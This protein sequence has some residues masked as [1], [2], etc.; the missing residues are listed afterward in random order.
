[1]AYR[2]EIDGLRAIAVGGVVA[3]HAGLAGLPGGFTGVDVFFVISGYLITGIIAGE[4]AAGRFSQLRFLERRI[5]RIVPAL[6][7][8]LAVTAVAAWTLLTPADFR[9]FAQSLTASAVFGSNLLFARGSDYFDSE[10]G[11]QPLLHTWTLGVEEQ[12]YLLFP[13][14]LMACRRWRPQAMLPVVVVL[15]LASFMLALLMAGRWPLLAF[16]LLPT[17]MWEFALGAACALLPAGRLAHLSALPR[18]RGLLAL[19]GLGLVISGFV[20]IRPETPAPGAMFLLPTLGTAMVILFAGPSDPAGRLLGLRP[21][22]WLGLVSFGTYLWHQPV[23]TLGRYVWF[24][25]LPPG[26]TVALVAA[27]IA[28]GAASYHWLEQPVRQRRL[29][30][31]RKALLLV[32]AGSLAVS[33]LAGVAGHLRA[34]MPASTAEA[35]RFGGLQPP[36]PPSFVSVTPTEPPRYILYGDSHAIQY[37]HALTAR[38]GESL[39][40]TLPSCLAA[41]EISNQLPGHPE[42]DACRAMPERLVALTNER[43]VRTII[44]AQIWER[45]VF[46]GGSETPIAHGSKAAAR[47]LT[48][49]LARLADRLPAGTRI[50]LIGNSPAAWP[51]A[52]SMYDGWLRCRAFRNVDCP[53]SYPASKAQGIAI[54]AAL[55]ALANRDTRFV[56]IDTHA[57]LCPQRRCTV[58]EGGKLN[59]WD[60]H[61]LTRRGADRVVATIPAGLL[62][63]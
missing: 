40:L 5:R 35:M 56:F 9:P 43:R 22:V 49:G 38:F 11:M 52:P 14:L 27:S 23:L 1:M 31:E 53:T 25:G 7:V 29:L 18:V 60:A 2:P 15:G 33:A 17:R 61:H 8:M 37:H 12:F 39:L 57:A 3:H 63:R 26:A 51:A 28:L 30:A 46:E 50:I 42:G 21:F 16:Y 34:L 45:T 48:A 54:N 6:A 59:Y 19:I 36:L 20:L 41:L 55:R 47:A 10:A 58:V 62:D 4:M 44:W 13:L 24:G 32:C